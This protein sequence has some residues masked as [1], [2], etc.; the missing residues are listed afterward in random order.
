MNN[1]NITINDIDIKCLKIS[2]LRR[3]F[4]AVNQESILFNDSILNNIK[5][6]NLNANEK[7]IVSVAKIANAHELL[8]RKRG[9]LTKVGDRGNKLSGGE[10]QELVLPVQY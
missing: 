6:G 5:L 10:K 3:L 4:G 9:Y 8:L 1:G 2:D 7:E